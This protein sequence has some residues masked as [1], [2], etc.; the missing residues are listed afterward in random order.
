MKADKR[1]VVPCPDCEEDIYLES[2]PRKGQKVTCP[3]CWAYL[4]VISLDP[5]KL[6][7]EIV[8]FEEDWN[9]DWQ[10]VEGKEKPS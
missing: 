6:S 5:L 3:N 10:A 2:T 1:I 9:V 8:E 4:E 7:W